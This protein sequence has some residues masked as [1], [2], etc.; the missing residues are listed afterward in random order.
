M[1]YL[2]FASSHVWIGVR[3]TSVSYSLKQPAPK[4][5]LL[6]V[7]LV[8]MVVCFIILEE[9]GLQEAI[10]AVTYNNTTGTLS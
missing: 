9:E 5:E 6:G 4:V 3:A 2:L 10:T 7:L 1:V 8:Q